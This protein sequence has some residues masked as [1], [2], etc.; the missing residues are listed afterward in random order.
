MS[1]SHLYCPLCGAAGVD[2]LDGC[3]ASWGKI[4]T[5]E[6][7][8]PE[9]FT[10]HRLTV[11]A[12]CLQHPERFMISTKS[13]A[14][15]LAAMCWTMERGLSRHLPEEL[16]V[17]VDGPKTFARLPPPPPLERG[18][19]TQADLACVTTLREYETRSWEWARAAW[20]AW[21]AHHAQARAWV[22]AACGHK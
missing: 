15:H 21:S 14:A 11:D 16:K 20:G 2:G 9:Y 17:F 13:A 6:F 4:G 12:Y 18:S 10:F 1:E 22:R 8:H 19:I 3:L 7:A 5:R